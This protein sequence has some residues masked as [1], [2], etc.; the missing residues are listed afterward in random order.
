RDDEPGDPSEDGPI[1]LALGAPLR[2]RGRAIAA[3]RCE[4]ERDQLAARITGFLQ[5]LGVQE[6]QLTVVGCRGDRALEL[7][8]SRSRV[9]HRLAEVLTNRSFV[10]RRCRIEAMHRLLVIALVACS[11][12]PPSKTA[13]IDQALAR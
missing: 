3:C 11:S 12:P 4:R 13:A 10:A 9:C 5:H 7:R 8:E 2:G 1:G 6:A